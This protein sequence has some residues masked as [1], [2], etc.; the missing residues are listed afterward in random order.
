LHRRTYLL[1]AIIVVL[2]QI[3][4]LAL[5]CAMTINGVLKITLGAGFKPLLDRIIGKKIH[6]RST[7]LRNAL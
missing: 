3:R 7:S 5:I 1:L 4:R 6:H 2:E